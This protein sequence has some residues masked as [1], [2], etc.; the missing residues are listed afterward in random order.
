MEGFRRELGAESI[1][2]KDLSDGSMRW[3]AVQNEGTSLV[4]FRQDINLEA[5]DAGVDGQ[6]FRL[7]LVVPFPVLS[8]LVEVGFLFL[9]ALATFVFLSKQILSMR[10]YKNNQAGKLFGGYGAITVSYYVLQNKEV[11]KPTT[12]IDILENTEYVTLSPKSVIILAYNSILNKA[13]KKAPILNDTDDLKQ[14]A[15]SKKDCNDGGQYKNIQKISEDGNI[16]IIRSEKKMDNFDY[17]KLY[18]DGINYPRTYYDKD[19]E[20]GIID[21]EAITNLTEEPD[22]KETKRLKR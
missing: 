22:S 19:G 17:P 9:L 21:K 15:L 3:T 12:I 1:V 6:R 7:S 8:I 20:Y 5:S 18:I 11:T 4:P 16:V 10:I 2:L 14:K 13:M